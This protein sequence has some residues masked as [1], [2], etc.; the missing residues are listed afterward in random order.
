MSQEDSYTLAGIPL[1]PAG[2]PSCPRVH[3]GLFLLP[4]EQIRTSAPNGSAAAIVGSIPT[5][6]QHF[7][8]FNRGIS[9]G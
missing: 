9:Q 7:D 1:Q 4:T 2:P 3:T 5:L 6:E 8:G